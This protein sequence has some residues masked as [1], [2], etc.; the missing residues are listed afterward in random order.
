MDGASYKQILLLAKNRERRTHE[1]YFNR[2]IKR[3]ELLAVFEQ[4]R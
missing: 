2:V 3:V 4:S 1:V